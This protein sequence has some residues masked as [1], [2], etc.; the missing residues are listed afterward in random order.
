MWLRS[1]WD[2]YERLFR[3]ILGL[4]RLGPESLLYVR[5]VI[6]QGPPLDDGGTVLEPGAQVLDL[7]LANEELAAMARPGRSSAWQLRRRLRQE[8]PALHRA[9]AV[10]YPGASAVIGTSVL[11]WAVGDMGFHL[12]MLPAGPAAWWLRIYM[13][14]LARIYGS[15]KVGRER[16]AA[17]SRKVGMLWLTREELGSMVTNFSSSSHLPH[18]TFSGLDGRMRDEMAGCTAKGGTT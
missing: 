17:R 2:R 14:W 18:Q 9:L 7:H 15:A 3:R 6:Y 13:R 16:S 5:P 10:E 11:I 8:L 12:T 1:I 4:R